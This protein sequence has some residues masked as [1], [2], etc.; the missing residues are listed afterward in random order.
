MLN[1][2]K[3]DLW[4]TLNFGKMKITQEQFDKL[5][6]LDRIEY[7]QKESR[8]REW[9]SDSLGWIGLKATLILYGFSFLLIPQGYTLWGIESLKDFIHLMDRVGGIFIG[10]TLLGFVVDIIF[11]LIRMNN[12]KMLN[13]KYFNFK[14]EVKK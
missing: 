7:R 13:D 6:Q 14:T 4:R 11:S 3:E 2:I 12:L 8:I 9:Y 1:K 10:I 5:K